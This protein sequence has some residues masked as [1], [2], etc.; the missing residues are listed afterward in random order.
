MP[1][2]VADLGIDPEEFRAAIDEL[3]MAAF[4][5]P[6]LRTNPRMPLVVELRQLPAAVAAPE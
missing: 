1:R 6:S 4:R 2:T 3:A 5:D